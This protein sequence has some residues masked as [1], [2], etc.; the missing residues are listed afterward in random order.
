MH[1]SERQINNYIS[2]ALPPGELLEVD[3]HLAACGACMRKTAEAQN[4]TTSGLQRS[5][6]AAEN[7]EHLS[8]AQMSDY[9]DGALADVE[10]EHVELHRDACR[11]C[12]AEIEDL[13]QLRESL[14]ATDT[15]KLAKLEIVTT[16]WYE[17]LL[18]NPLFRI[19]ASAAAI[20]VVIAF[21]WSA[22]RRP[23][24]DIAKVVEPA[25]ST[26]DV[27]SNPPANQSE[28]PPTNTET[29]ILT[30]LNDGGGKIELDQE[31]KISG[32]STSEF[33]TKLRAALKD[34]SIEIPADIRE[35]RSSAGV[36]M[37][38]SENGL[39][40]KIVGPVG[41]VVESQRPTLSWQPLKDAESYKVGIY[42]SNFNQVVVSPELHS[43]NWTPPTPL[44]RGS[45]YQWQ[46][47][48][49]R[50]GEEVKSPVR[51]APEAK[52]KIVSQSRLA[53]IEKA[54][55]SAGNS[56]LLLGVV[57]AN[58]GLLDDAEREFQI[59]LKNNPKSDIAKKLLSKVRSAR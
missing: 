40:F 26:N 9:V 4:L 54:K 37:G 47:T 41:K 18:S 7:I 56:H 55:R 21:F 30:S 46:V 49:I 24:Q 20:L 11:T 42:D 48:A 25:P 23:T 29:K 34:Q 38:S 52:F 1:L 22:Q 36:L 16:S 33:D 31:G 12:A 45:V 8:Y 2:H 28:A 17:R 3:D 27:S 44:E 51:P 14:A 5:L 35:L 15:P 10:R 39:P 53:D 57:Y 58:A 59:L 13:V 32:I 43:T 50:S 19:A 6:F